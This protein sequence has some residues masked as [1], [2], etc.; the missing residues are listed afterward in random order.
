MT[1]CFII[2]GSENILC[3]TQ[4]SRY[5]CVIYCSTELEQECIFTIP[6]NVACNS[7]IFLSSEHACIL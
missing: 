5:I 4:N 3:L 1:F 6:I 7:N 2:H